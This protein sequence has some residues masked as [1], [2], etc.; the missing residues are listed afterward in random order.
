MV[1]GAQRCSCSSP[2]LVQEAAKQ[3][4]SVD[5]GR[6][7]LADDSQSRTGRWG[8]KRQRPVRAMGVV[9]RDV[10][11][12]GLFEVASANDQQPVQALGADGLHPALGNGVGVGGLDRRTDDLRTDR[13]PE[14]IEGP[15][16]L[17]VAVA[18][19]EPEGGGWLAA[20]STHP[21][22]PRN[23]PR[24]WPAGAIAG[25][26]QRAVTVHPRLPFLA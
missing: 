13:A 17:A 25:N 16:E 6:L 3:I 26:E 7:I 23:H 24:F 15:G 9:V 14:V 5:S 21:L 12:K 20:G 10:D 2:V 11:P 18:E 4:A 8:L 22:I 19:Q 1:W